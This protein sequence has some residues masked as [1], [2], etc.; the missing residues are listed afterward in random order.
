L[1]QKV[2][3]DS[4]YHE[5]NKQIRKVLKEFKKETKQDDNNFLKKVDKTKSDLLLESSSA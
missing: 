1:T 5:I 3:T 4:E 2:R